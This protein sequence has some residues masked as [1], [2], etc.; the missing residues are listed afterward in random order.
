MILG[1]GIEGASDSVD[2]SGV[3]ALTVSTSGN[4]GLKQCTF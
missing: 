1:F 3:V 4:E 2:Q